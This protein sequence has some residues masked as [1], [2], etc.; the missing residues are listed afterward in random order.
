MNV[1][2]SPTASARGKSI[3]RLLKQ[4]ITALLADV[5]IEKA[6]LGIHLVAAPEMTRLNETFSGTPARP[7]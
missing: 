7:M 4:I 3:A 6:E 1:D 5:K 2:S